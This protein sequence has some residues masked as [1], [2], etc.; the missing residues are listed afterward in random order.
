MCRKDL[1][2]GVGLIAFG[3]GLLTA[4]WVE[5]TF[6]RWVLGLGLLVSGFLVLQKK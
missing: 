5:S 1:L 3:A 6:L 2:L 4:G